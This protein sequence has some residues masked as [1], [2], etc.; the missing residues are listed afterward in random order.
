MRC[1][2]GPLEGVVLQ[3]HHKDYLPGKM[4]WQYP[5]EL[6][7]TLCQGCHASEHGKIR[8]FSGWDCIG[9]DDLGDL[10]GECEVC[11]S[12][13]RYVFFVQ[14]AKWPSLEVGETCCDHLTGT[15]EASEYRRYLGRLQRFIQSSRWK[16][17]GSG[18]LRI[19]QKSLEIIIQPFDREFRLV[20][21]GHR[22][23]RRFSSIVDAKTFLLH[24]LED[25]TVEAFLKNQIRRRS[26]KE[27]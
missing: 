12:A 27:T 15:E 23:K 16:S 24:S 26:T 19:V 8:P 1:G 22:G 7:E 20:I 9:Y 21:E 3:I 17:D 11:G 5:Y 10:C 25:G 6:C 4:P 2:R 18:G 13:I 14:H